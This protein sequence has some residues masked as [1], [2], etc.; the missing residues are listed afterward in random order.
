[1]PTRGMKKGTK[2]TT[3]QQD[4]TREQL[5]REAR[6]MNVEGRSSMNKEQLRRAVNRRKAGS[7]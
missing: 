2:R 1:M 5:Y 3:R 6:R 7:R 4:K